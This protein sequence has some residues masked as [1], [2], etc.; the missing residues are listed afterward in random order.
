MGNDERAVSGGSGRLDGARR[1]K[2]GECEGLANWSQC[3]VARFGA[4]A[5]E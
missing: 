3:S 2:Q 1:E 5:L 4:E